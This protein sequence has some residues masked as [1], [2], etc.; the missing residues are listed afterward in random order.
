MLKQKLFVKEFSKYNIFH[1][2]NTSY[3]THQLNLY[4]DF[5]SLYF[6]IIY[7]LNKNEKLN[8]YIAVL[9]VYILSS[10]FINKNKFLVCYLPIIMFSKTAESVSIKLSTN[11]LQTS[12]RF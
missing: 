8:S 5:F 4:I 3:Y 6:H 7:N 11:M 10:I 1:I 9:L 12:G 2:K